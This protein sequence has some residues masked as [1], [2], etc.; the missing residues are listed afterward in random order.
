[1]ILCSIASS[2][3]GNCIYVGND[4]TGILVDTGI[5]KK[6]ILEGMQKRDLDIKKVKAIVITHEHSDHIKGLGVMARSFKIPIYTTYMTAKAIRKI[7]SIGKIDE[8]LFNVLEADHDIYVDDIKVHAFSIAH[9]AV[10]PV[11]YSFSDGESKVCV[12]TDIGHYDDYIIENLRECSMLLIEANHDINMLQVGPYS[13]ML[14]QRILSD[15]GHLSNENC[16]RLL[17]EILSDKLK[18][19]LLGHLSQENNYPQLAYQTVKCILLEKND[20]IFNQITLDVAGKDN[21]S[22]IYIA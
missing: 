21:P 22:Q 7:E 17:C 6:K 8:S 4:N 14:K 1:M 20:N 12:T 16:G 2:S 13:Y 10:N 9:D 5:S 11:S 15:V 3:S 18:H 19:V